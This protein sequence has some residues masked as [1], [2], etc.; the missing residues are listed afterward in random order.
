MSDQPFPIANSVPP[1]V[2][3]AI[4]PDPWESLSVYDSDLDFDD[5]SGPD[6]M[7]EDSLD[8]DG[9]ASMAAEANERAVHDAVALEMPSPVEES[10]PIANTPDGGG[11]VFTIPLLC[12]G[13]AV[14]AACLLIPQADANRRLAYER[15][16]L[17]ADLQAV[18]KQVEKNDE[19]LRSVAD[20]PNLAERLAQ[21]QMKIIRKGNEVLRLKSPGASGSGVDDVSPFQITA[22]APAPQL[23]PY[24]PRGGTLANLCYNPKSRLYLMGAG[25]MAMAAGLVL[26]FGGKAD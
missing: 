18:E 2:P 1:A 6:V 10:E 14:I 7:I 12:A 3:S 24:Q 15:L 11:G 17:Q 8:P 21:R 16:K 9:A 20:D 26:G 5:D 25:L 22:V 4:T 13:I 19:F 23:P